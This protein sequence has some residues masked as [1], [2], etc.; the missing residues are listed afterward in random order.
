MDLDK[1]LADHLAAWGRTRRGW[2]KGGCL[3][4]LARVKGRSADDVAMAWVRF[5]ADDGVDTP[6]AFPNLTGPHWSEKVAPA[7]PPRPPKPDEACRD[8]GR[9][10]DAC[11]CEG[12]PTIRA[13]VP[14]PNATPRV[15][16]LRAVVAEVTADRCSHGPNCTEHRKATR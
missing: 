14:L 12:G 13:V 16:R 11:L 15:E 10:F 9:H 2:D 1:T 5:C 6:G 8:C 3:A 7:T 4:Q